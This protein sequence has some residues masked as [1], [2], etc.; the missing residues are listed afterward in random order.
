MDESG[1]KTPNFFSG[2]GGGGQSCTHS[3]LAFWSDHSQ[4]K[5]N[6]SYQLKTIKWSKY[7]SD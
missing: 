1:V 2:E 6:K 7:E 4:E 5:K 3:L